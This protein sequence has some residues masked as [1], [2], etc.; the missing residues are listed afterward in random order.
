MLTATRAVGWRVRNPRDSSRTRP[1]TR[2][3]RAAAVYLDIQD[4]ELKAGIRSQEDPALGSVVGQVRDG[5]LRLLAVTTRRRDPN[6]PD[7]PTVAEA[8]LPEYELTTWT[9]M[10]GPK[11]MPEDVTAALSKAANAALSEPRVRERLESTGTTPMAD[12]TPAST[13]AFLDREYDLY[14]RVVERIGLRLD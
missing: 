13:R 12:S 5:A 3:R 11:D 6:F 7:V 2:L 8:A 1:S 10:V 4:Y 9:A 14:A